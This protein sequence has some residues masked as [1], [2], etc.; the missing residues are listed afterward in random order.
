MHNNVENESAL[1]SLVSKIEY[2]TLKSESIV[3]GDGTF[4]CMF[5]QKLFDAVREH[6]FDDYRAN[7]QIT[8]G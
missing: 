1:H 5:F 7:M 2:V 8:V 6:I 3:D 4:D